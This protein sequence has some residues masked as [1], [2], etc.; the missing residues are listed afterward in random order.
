M[1]Y[2]NPSAA[3]FQM[4]FATTPEQIAKVE[5][6]PQHTLTPTP[7]PEGKNRF[8]RADATSPGPLEPAEPTPS[9]LSFA[10]TPTTRK[11]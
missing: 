4:K 6:P 3:V 11:H 10:K 7:G 5:S 9:W 1:R 8:V 2:Q